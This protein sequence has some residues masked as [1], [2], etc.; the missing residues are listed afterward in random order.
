MVKLVRYVCDRLHLSRQK[1][2]CVYTHEKNQSGYHNHKIL[3]NAILQ[4]SLNIE[5]KRGVHFYFVHFSVQYLK[6][7][8]KL[9]KIKLKWKKATKLDFNTERTAKW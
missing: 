1:F 9:N 2:L 5:T 4:I 7:K 8:Y 6:N 3:Q